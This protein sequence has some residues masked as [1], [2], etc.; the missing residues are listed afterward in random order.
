MRAQTKIQRAILIGVALLLLLAVRPE[1]GLFPTNADWMALERARESGDD[2]IEWQLLARFVSADPKDTDSWERMG[3]LDHRGGLCEQAVFEFEQAARHGNLSTSSLIPYGDCLVALGN[4][5]AA[6]DLLAPQLDT[7]EIPSGLELLLARI[8]LRLGDLERASYSIRLWAG[9]EAED[10][11]ARQYLGLIQVLS[12]PADGLATLRQAADLSNENENAYRQI[13]T[14]VNKGELQESQAYRALELGRAYGSLGEWE[15]A[16]FAF[17][18]AVA[19]D[20]EY[21]EAHAWLGEAQQQLGEDGSAELQKAL[22]LNPTSILA[23]AMNALALQRQGNIQAALATLEQIASQEPDNPQWLIALGQA[24]AQLGDL[25][26]A[27]SEFLKATK[28]Q[29][30]N[31]AVWQALAEFSLSYQY[32]VTSTGT[33]AANKAVLLAPESPYSLDLAGQAAIT[34]GEL[35]EAESYFKTAIERDPRYAPA[36][37]HLALIFFQREDINLGLHEL[38][39][40]AALG[41]PEA[42]NL[43]TQMTTQ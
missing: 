22:A 24:R 40:A 39:R 5:Q 20:P 31:V 14:A 43:L 42:Q 17:N 8:Y 32:Q 41:N 2:L 19:A 18:S 33:P 28:L 12:S 34:N 7:V 27:L 38:Q 36:H 26:G 29:P 15:M 23:Q 9:R 6:A 25:E 11:R 3:V 1:Q 10:A 37:L 13:Q 4:L 21:A 16:L 30:E 35:D